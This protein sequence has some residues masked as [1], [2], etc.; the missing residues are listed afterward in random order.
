MRIRLVIFPSRPAA[1]GDVTMYSVFVI[2]II[3]L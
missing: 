1:A 3:L 2:H